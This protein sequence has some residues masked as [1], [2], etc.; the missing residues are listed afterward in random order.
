M[1]ERAGFEPAGRSLSG[2][3]LFHT[4]GRSFNLT[5]VS[6]SMAARVATR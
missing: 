1:T 5:V 3:Y 2:K 4:E 6:D